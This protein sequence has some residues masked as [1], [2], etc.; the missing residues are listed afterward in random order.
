MIDII[1]FKYERD[2]RWGFGAAFPVFS[3][4]DGDWKHGE[5]V[6]PYPCYAH[7]AA[8][9]HHEAE[10]TAAV[11]PLPADVHICIFDRE[12]PSRTNGF[13]RIGTFYNHGGSVKKWEATIVL[14][15]KRIP[16]HPA[17]TRYLVSHEYGHAVAEHLRRVVGTPCE[18]GNPDCSRNYDESK[19]YREYEKLRA[20]KSPEFYGGGTWHA[21]VSELFANDFR[22][23]VA[24]SETEFWPHPG[25]PRPEELPAVREFWESQTKAALAAALTERERGA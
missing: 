20:F 25:F 15:G 19:L 24:G 18:C 13:T 10:V 6:D 11:F 21:S 16:P 1:E 4:P 8:L 7:D 23:I 3:I 22:I 9:V 14:Y 2:A 12:G 17:L 5:S